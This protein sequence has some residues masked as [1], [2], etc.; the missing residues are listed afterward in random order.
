MY[1]RILYII[2]KKEWRKI[3][4]LKESLVSGAFMNG[5][6]KK[7]KR[8]TSQA[9]ICCYLIIPFFILWGCYIQLKIHLYLNEHNLNIERFF[10]L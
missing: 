2:L 9:E 5:Q 6:F 1:I 3:R 7:R 8:Y 4:R 10:S